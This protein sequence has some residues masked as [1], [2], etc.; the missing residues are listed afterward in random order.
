MSN[1]VYGHEFMG[2]LQ[3]EGKRYFLKEIRFE[4]FTDSG[5]QTWVLENAVTGQPVELE[6]MPNQAHKAKHDAEM[7][8]ITSRIAAAQLDVV[9]N[10]LQQQREMVVDLNKAGDPDEEK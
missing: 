9:I 2:E 8:Q 10:D 3:I 7:R 5:Q 6:Y 4:E 1:W